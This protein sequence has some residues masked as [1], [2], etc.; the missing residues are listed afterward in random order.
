MWALS[1]PSLLDL[2][3]ALLAAW[4]SIWAPKQKGKDAWSASNS[5]IFCLSF[6]Q[7]RTRDCFWVFFLSRR[8]FPYWVTVQAWHGVPVVWLYR[9]PPGQQHVLQWTEFTLSPSHPPPLV[10]TDN[11]YFFPHSRSLFF[12][13]F[14]QV[15]KGAFLFPHLRKKVGKNTLSSTERQYFAFSTALCAALF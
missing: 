3:R 8:S 11:F 5:G 9:Q 4:T 12:F 7:L 1:L 13:F 15:Q 6:S 10:Y 2:D 14:F